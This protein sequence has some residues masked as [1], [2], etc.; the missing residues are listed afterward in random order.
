MHD[1]DCQTA[2][3]GDN[4][5]PRS[6]STDE[7]RARKLRFTRHPTPTKEQTAMGFQIAPDQTAE[8]PARLDMGTS[9]IHQQTV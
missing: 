4:Q 2:P 3:G 7:E 9:N 1:K 6:R 5:K 8:P